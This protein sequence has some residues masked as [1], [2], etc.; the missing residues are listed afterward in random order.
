[1]PKT[2]N[3]VKSKN[4]KKSKIDSQLKSKRILDK[5]KYKSFRLHKKIKNPKKPIIGSFKLFKASLS[6]IMKNKKVFAGILTV[7]FLLSLILVTGI[8]GGS[9][10]AGLKDT[11]KELAKGGNFTTGLS[12]FAVLLSGGSGSTTQV[13]GI[14][15]TL[16]IV[17][18]SLVSIWTLRQ[19][20]AKEK[21]TTKIAFYRSMYPLIPFILVIFVIV[22]QFLPLI[23]GS[24]LYGLVISQGLAVTAIEKILWAMVV[25]CL[26]LL[27]LYMV[28]SS[29]FALYIVTL[30][31]L[32]PMKAL[33]SARELVLY[34]RWMVMRKIL[35]LPLALLI[36]A[37]LIMIPILLYLTTIA[38]VVFVILSMFG[39]LVV[40]SYM[41]RL[42][43]ELL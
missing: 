15:Q 34:R 4:P 17:I 2:T 23:M 26:A 33:R 32:T 16:I 5:P 1:M 36:V 28:T 25:F 27:T 12:L 11:V 42:Y 10:L 21:I 22:L 13:G 24:A 19:T 38:Q 35:F 3:P 7:Y 43:R 9:D 37:A 29:V 14:Y 18:I 30:P 39:L 20:Y 31:D 40:H 8:L 6:H 41:Y